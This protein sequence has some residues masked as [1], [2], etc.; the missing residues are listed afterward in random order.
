MEDSDSNIYLINIYT[1]TK[2]G[3]ILF[4]CPQDIEQKQKIFA[5]QGP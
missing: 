3:E 1:F 2:F 4:I 5:N